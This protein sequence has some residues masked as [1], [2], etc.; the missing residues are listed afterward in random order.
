[1]K[2]V[3][4]N[5]D[6]IDA[7]GIHALARSCAAAGREVIVVAPS[8]DM[9]GSASA[10]GKVRADQRI[11]TRR[12]KLPG[13]PDVPAHAIDGPPGLA[14]MTA[15]LGGFGDPPDAVL[16]GINAGPNTGHAILHSGTVGAA[17]TAATFGVSALAV[18]VEVSD[19]MCWETA[20]RLVE[21]AVERL[22]EA[23]AGTVLN[24]NVPA[25]PPER[26]PE[27]R[28]AHL[29]RF[30][31]V[32]VAIAGAGDQW[33][34]MEY[35]A[36]GI[37]LGPESDTALLER[38]FATITAIEGIAEVSPDELPTWGAGRRELRALLRRVPADAAEHDG[39][40]E[41]HS[42]AAKG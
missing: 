37:E 5:D 2:V 35:R 12:V 22:C 29:D 30:G 34:Q 10:I 8:E 28:W 31:S 36:T 7:P 16:S 11:L 9:S 24:L 42:F 4:V 39:R 41:T 23:P 40:A 1:L 18:S 21:P 13:C 27:L 20:C 15:C 19:P 3:L 17:L 26:M 38:G 14:A 33:L 25:V 32:R 6:G